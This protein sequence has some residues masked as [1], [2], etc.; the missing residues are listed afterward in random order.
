M[1]IEHGL[2]KYRKRRLI[3]AV[4]SA[5]KKRKVFQLAAP[6]ARAVYLAGDFNE[7]VPDGRLLNE[8]KNGIWKTT[9]TLAPGVY[10]YRFVVDGEW[11]DDPRCAEK[12]PNGLG[13]E[14]C[15]IRV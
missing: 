6:S 5:G 4:K 15:L 7:W 14:N 3:M 10:Q 9:V 2:N 13:E 1:F 11:Y 8:G 12:T